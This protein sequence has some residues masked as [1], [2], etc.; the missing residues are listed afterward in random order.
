MCFAGE[1]SWEDLYLMLGYNLA[2]PPYVRQALFSRS[3]DNDDLLPK[4]RKPVL[5][6]Q[7]AEDA[8]VKPAAI[9]QHKAAIAHAQVHLMANAGRLQ[10]FGMMPPISIGECGPLPK[11]LNVQPRVLPEL[12]RRLTNAR[13]AE[14]PHR[15]FSSHRLA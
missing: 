1:P 6:T 11:R 3:F 4:I 7:G 2:V 5:I 14:L 15:W 13:P 9:G 8:I 10:P 12:V